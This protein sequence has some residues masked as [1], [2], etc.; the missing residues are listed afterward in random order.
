MKKIIY[1]FIGIFS[2]QQFFPC[3]LKAE[4]S[5]DQ[6]YA[7]RSQS[8]S[9]FFFSDLP[10]HLA[11]DMKESF[12][13]WG[14]LAFLLG[15]GLSVGLTK[16][17]HNLQSKFQPNDL[18]GS[19]ANTVLST[20][21]SPYVWGGASL[22]VTAVGAGIHDEKLL[23]TGESLLETFFW[24]QSLSLGLKYAVGRDRPNGDSRGFPSAHTSASFGSAAVL[25]SMYGYKAG[26]PAYLFSSL[27][28]V[29]RVDSYHHFLSDVLMGATLGTVIGY[30]TAKYHKKLHNFSLTPQISPNE[31]GMLFQSSF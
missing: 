13:G 9:R 19:K 27:V 29:S 22:V 28:A 18:L 20:A 21:G 5:Q 12:W 6:A 14:G 25:Q 23:T 24:T 8:G 16:T 31:Y 10:K 26:I 11:Y 17:D 30:G 4:E 1:L 7:E 3:L 2:L 15:T